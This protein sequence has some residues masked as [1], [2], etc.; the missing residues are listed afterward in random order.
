MIRATILLLV[1]M[2]AACGDGGASAARIGPSPGAEAT[3]KPE[4]TPLS[5]AS[6]TDS[7]AGD[8]FQIPVAAVAI[9]YTANGTCSLGVRLFAEANEADNADTPQ[10]QVTG[11]VP[12]YLASHGD[13]GTLRDR[14][15]R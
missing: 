3:A 15:R 12:W 9:D 11:E 1:L 6:G 13:A 8:Y 5:T 2:L 14:A 4:P 10:V 7:Y